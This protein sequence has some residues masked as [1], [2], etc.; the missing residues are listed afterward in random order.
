MK[1]DN[2]GF[3]FSTM[4]YGTLALITVVLFAILSISQSSKDTT[5][6][7]GEAILAKLNECVSEEIALENCYSSG[8]AC[9][10]TSYHGCLGYS[11]TTTPDGQ[12]IISEKLKESIVTSGDGL[13]V[14]PYVDKKYIYVGSNPKNFIRYSNKLWRI[15]SIEQD[16]SLKLIDYTANIDKSWDAGGKD[17]WDSSTLKSYLNNDYLSTIADSSKMV[18]G[19]WQATY[20]YPAMSTGHLSIPELVTQDNDQDATAG[21]FSQVGILSISDYMKATTVQNCKNNMLTA[22]GCTSWLSSYKGW[23]LN[24]DAGVTNVNNAYFFDNGDKLSEAVTSTSKKV[25]PVIVL[26]RTAVIDKGTGTSSDPYT[27]K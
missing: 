25:Y 26:N 9:D 27:L 1:L 18:S 16:G 24:I 23:T 7:Y 10:A 4:L 17:N 12:K 14:D 5:Y 19:K 13:Y 11:N 6:Y 8:A 3:A 20:V 21:I 2:K 15:V 22:T